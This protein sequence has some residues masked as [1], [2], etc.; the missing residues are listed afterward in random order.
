MDNWWYVN[1]VESFVA[2][3]AADSLPS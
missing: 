1:G 3:F 2:P